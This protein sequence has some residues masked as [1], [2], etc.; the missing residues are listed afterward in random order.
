M[1]ILFLVI[2]T[3][4]TRRVYEK[5]LRRI[6]EERV[7]SDVVQVDSTTPVP[8]PEPLPRAVPPAPPIKPEF[9]DQEGMLLTYMVAFCLAQ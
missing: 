1:V 8:V 6:L 3:E 9:S 5:K 4:S 7:H 2:L